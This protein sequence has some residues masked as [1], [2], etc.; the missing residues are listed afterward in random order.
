MSMTELHRNGVYLIS[1]K[2]VAADNVRN[3][4]VPDT[5]REKTI[6]YQ[7]IRK[8]DKGTDPKKLRLKFDALVSHDITYVGIIQTA[9]AS[10]M[11]K[12]PIPYAMSKVKLMVQKR[13]ALV[14]ILS[15]TDYL[16]IAMT[17]LSLVCLLSI[18]NKK[19]LRSTLALGKR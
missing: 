2:P 19:A 15:I 14:H 10:G 4:T 7:I 13:G 18:C 1:G 3:A 8:H 5:A 9:R 17:R 11:T 6:A 12:F 16:L